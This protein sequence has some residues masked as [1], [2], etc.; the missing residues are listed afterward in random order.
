L[1]LFA[2]DRVKRKIAPLPGQVKMYLGKRQLVNDK[3]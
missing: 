3:C 2:I 1:E